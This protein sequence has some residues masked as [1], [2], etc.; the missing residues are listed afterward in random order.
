[1]L[2]GEG[3]DLRA[4]HHGAVVVDQLADC[5]RRLQRGQAAQI[6][7]RLGMAGADQDAAILGDQRKDVTGADE[8]GASGIVVGERANCRGAFLG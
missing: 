4:A 2:V 6:D 7:C 5:G 1:M 8:I 3:G